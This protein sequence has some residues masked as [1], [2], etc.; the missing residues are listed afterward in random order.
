MADSVTRLAAS[1]SDRYS[2]LLLRLLGRYYDESARFTLGAAALIS[3]LGVV[4]WYLPF[5]LLGPAFGVAYG[6]LVYR[7]ERRWSA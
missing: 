6:A 2:A 3:A 4:I 1:A 7:E 5:V